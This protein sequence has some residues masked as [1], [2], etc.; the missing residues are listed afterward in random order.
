MGED[1]GE[2]K[3]GEGDGG[4]KMGRKG[5]GEVMG[6]KGMGKGRWGE[7]AG[8]RRKGMDRGTGLE[9]REMGWIIFLMGYA[10][11]WRCFS[12]AIPRPIPLSGSR[13]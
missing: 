4:K 9:K 3:W 10:R 13:P 11:P 7:G 1:M 5:E 12:P 2:R 6:R 8:E